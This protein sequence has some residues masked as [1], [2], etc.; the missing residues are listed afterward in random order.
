[1]VR[2]GKKHCEGYKYNPKKDIIEQCIANINKDEKYCEPCKRYEN[3]TS[4]EIGKIKRRDSTVRCCDRCHRLHFKG[5]D[6]SKCRNKSKKNMDGKEW[7][8]RC[9]RCLKMESENQKRRKGDKLRCKGYQKPKPYHYHIID[10]KKL[11]RCDIFV[12]EEN[13]FC[14]DHK[15]MEDYGEIEWNN[16][17]QCGNC[18]RV[19][20]IPDNGHQ[21]LKCR[22]IGEEN[23]AKAKIKKEDKGMKYCIHKNCPNALSDEKKYEF[24]DYCGQHQGEGW[25]KMMDDVGIKVCAD[26]SN[27]HRVV[28]KLGDKNKRC[29]ECLDKDN[30]ADKKRRD[31]WVSEIYN[32]ECECIRCKQ[33][34]PI[35]QFKT[36]NNKPSKKCSTCL[37]ELR[38]Y[39]R[40]R[41]RS[42]RDYMEYER[43]KEIK[44]MR[45]Q[46]RKNNP[47]KAAKY[48]NG[49]RE[50]LKK[51]IGIKKFHELRAAESRKW[52]EK[53]PEKM[54]ER[55]KR[56]K[57][58]ISKKIYDYKY[59]AEKRGKDYELTDEQT[60]DLIMDICYYCG[61]KP[62]LDLD[63]KN[64]TNENNDECDVEANVIGLNGIDRKNNDKGYTI[65]NVVSCCQ[66]CNYMK[67]AMDEHEFIFSIE[68]IL[69]MN[70][71]V[72]GLTCPDLFRDCVSTN[73]NKTKE[74]A[75]KRGIPFELTL[76][77]FKKIKSGQCY[78]CYKNNTS[79][80]NN[81]IDRVD[82]NGSYVFHNCQ[83]CCGIC[84]QMKKCY[85]LK[86]YLLQ[87]RK[88]YNYNTPWNQIDSKIFMSRCNQ[89]Y[90]KIINDA[91]KKSDNT[92]KK[93]KTNDFGLKFSRGVNNQE[94]NIDDS[95]VQNNDITHSNNSGKGDSETDKIKNDLEDVKNQL[96]RL[97]HGEE[98]KKMRNTL[99]KRKNRL[100]HRL[101]VG[102]EKYKKEQ[103]EAKK[104]NRD[105]KNK[106]K[107]QKK[108][109]TDKEK[110]INKLEAQHKYKQKKR[111]EVSEEKYKEDNNKYMR[112]YRENNK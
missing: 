47:E 45:R 87:M 59:S 27:K 25:K 86:D 3:Y 28:L 101:I 103:A 55:Y 94:I 66:M 112:E 61:R 6:L 11:I 38:I 41:N 105:E 13:P 98:N 58:N 17:Y 34:K 92:R 42:D 84:N 49:Y 102:N 67:F 31:E 32:D 2:A 60:Q 10:I 52:K 21:C 46:W 110:A 100:E 18:H 72:D 43:R 75:V 64:D 73:Y 106:D 53:N 93:N 30:I 65:D 82:S 70:H 40:T 29:R 62:N 109:L 5:K 22:K 9:D 4:E 15:H 50:R 68:H 16:L 99:T 69:T 83:A 104:R 81:G 108:L 14:E 35:N 80:H 39:D 88:I 97:G 111:D 8:S 36:L 74:S 71:I 85:D 23:R 26:Y 96:S 90:G 78:I 107:P 12:S 37:E 1:M 54:Q 24:K 51:K 7:I 57:V 95:I 91:V 89:T 44:E 56:D 77:E 33:R 20:Y 19:V 48:S 76:N 63:L 79:T